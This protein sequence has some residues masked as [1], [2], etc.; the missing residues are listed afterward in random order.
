[1]NLR[2]SPFRFFPSRVSLALGL[3]LLLSTTAAR[4][5]NYTYQTIDDP[6]AVFGSTPSGISGG[7]IVGWYID[8]FDHYNGYIYNIATK[9][10]TTLNDPNAVLGTSPAGT[11][12]N[13]IDGNNIVG[14]YY[15]NTSLGHGFLYLPNLLHPENPYTTLDDPAAGATDP[16]Y[17]NPTGISGGN[18]VGT[19]LNYT[20]QFNS[21]I[22]SFIFNGT[23]YTTIADPAAVADTTYASGIDGVNVVGWY[24]VP[25]GALGT[26]PTYG[27]V[28]NITTTNFTTTLSDPG[29][30][31]ATE[32]K[33][34]SGGNI[35]GIYSD[36]DGNTHGF[37]Y[38]GTT[39]NYTTLDDPLAENGATYAF[40]IDSGGNIVGQYEDANLTYHGFLA[41]TAAPH[42]G[43][44]ITTQPAS[45]N[46]TAPAAANF[47][48]VASGNGTLKYQWFFNDKTISGATKP[49]YAIAKTAA[50]NAGNYTVRVSNSL[51][52][53]NST[54]A[55]LVV[56]TAPK[57][58]TQPKALTLAYGASGNL[59]VV[60]TGTALVYQWH[61]NS[62]AIA[63]GNVTGATSPT[64]HF[65][66][67]IPADAG[68]YT[69]TVSNS[70]G[71]SST[72]SIAKVTYKPAAPKI[73]TQPQPVSPSLGGIATFTVTAFGSPTL[74]YQWTFKGKPVTGGNI[75]GA[76]TA[77]LTITPVGSA[78]A[79]TYQVTVSNTAGSVKST[80]VKLTVQ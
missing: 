45:A 60:A 21:V 52:S 40:G 23:S 8:G 48:V 13:G 73:T 33:G 11:I 57:I 50:T 30:F 46:V 7:N 9:T 17:T 68:S 12:A 76:T 20:S 4:A 3:A 74:N 69:V 44:V 36:A 47:T 41:T 70:Y 24:S 49:T 26:G 10:F 31:S 55:V 27:F 62:G 59:T 63:D 72:S 77:N 80:A 79:G 16:S 25:D 78:N 75:F 67:A 28:Y 29:A 37:L 14:L 15:D 22:G 38:N 65:P 6:K 51:G 61:Q 54:A 56:N 34:I 32:A 58:T 1:M 53:I 39:G 35:V 2:P 5:Q 43:P 71:P 66:F 42:P 19:Y 18:I 64:L